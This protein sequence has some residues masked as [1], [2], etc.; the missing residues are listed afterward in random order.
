MTSARE[1]RDKAW[2]YVRLPE[3]FKSYISFELRS[4]GIYELVALEGL[5]SKVASNRPGGSYATKD[6]FTPHPSIPNAWKYFA[7]LD[8]TIVLMNGE[9]VAPI[10]FEQ[11]IRDS[12]YVTEAVLFGSGKARVGMMIIPANAAHG[13]SDDEIERLLVPI[14]AK[15]NESMPG[16]AQLSLEMVKILPIGTEYPRTDKGTVIRA[17]FY[18]TFEAQIEEIYESA[19]VSSGELCLSE[20]ELRQ[21]IRKELGN[22]LSPST[23]SVLQDDTDFFS[24]G[25][26]SLQA[27]QLR[28]M[29]SKNIRTNGQKLTSNIVFDFPSINTLAP[30]LYRLRTGGASTF[31]ST[32]TK[33]EGLIAEYSK[34]DAHVPAENTKE[35]QYLV[36]TGATGSLGAHLV[37]QLVLRSDVKKVYCLVRA[38]S[39]SNARLRV[40][41]S[42]RE[43]SVYHN[44]P[45]ES[46]NKLVAVS[47]D[48]SKVSLGLSPEL[49]NEIASE[50][51]GLIH[52]AWSVNFNL[53]LGSFEADCIA[54]AH[55]LIALCLKAQRPDPACFNFC[56]SVST[57]AATKGDFVPEA[58]PESLEYAQN[59]GY[60]Q[61]K[62]VTEHI[63]VA[64][65]KSYGIRTRVLRVGQ[66]VA[67]TVHGIWNATEA[68]PLMMQAGLTM[69]AIPRLDE[70]P[71][72]LP[73]DVVASSI[74]DIS[75]SSAGPGVMNVVNH[76]SF[77]WTRDLLPALHRAGLEFS[78]PGQRE[79]V[80]LLRKSNP[81]PV[82]NPPIKLVEFFA[83]KYDNDLPRKGLTYNTSYARFLSPSL[84]AAPVLDQALV[85]KFVQQFLK[86]SWN[87]ITRCS[88][89]KRLI[90]IAGPCG[91]GKSTVAKA[92]SK[93][94]NIPWIEGDNLHSESSIAKM[95]TG[96]PLSDED[97]WSCLET[98]K[99]TALLQ[100]TEGRGDDIIVTCSALKRAYR[101]ELRK[102]RVLKTVFVML[103]G[104]QDVLKQR[105]ADR[106]GHYVG[107]E[108]VGSQLESLESPG[109]EETDIIPVDVTVKKEEV[110][111]EVLGVLRD[112]VAGVS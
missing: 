67:D 98:V 29:L 76:Q 106:E 78:E 89:T 74:S 30:E 84:A 3:A 94:F 23:L 63:C 17:A 110:V 80:E 59:M 69:G 101:D 5:P 93:E 44:L 77:H 53:G 82:A 91:A 42:M 70:N 28:S 38:R 111:E 60:A 18:R 7:R 1:P 26:D 64:T 81:D 4:P 25:V 105:T 21:F 73:V 24:I 72:W 83:S 88:S 100:L 35:G 10:A 31:V 48:F 33:M 58:L 96:T 20:F 102:S 55:N 47:A 14:L 56:S 8:D 79:W 108:M 16:Y 95:S 15:A 50:I 62:L 65:A 41:H 13:L 109:V 87:T 85:D 86:T 40:I 71:L 99:A 19:E 75:L 112:V 22:I 57:V 36:I 66:V 103:Q 90:I 43:R 49:Y 32:T 39:L 12:K 52:C 104:S 107:T 97:R 34:L 37:S 54:G 2:D 6:L 68:I 46:R 9:K 51:T 45:L 92:V 61:S 27:I 11:S